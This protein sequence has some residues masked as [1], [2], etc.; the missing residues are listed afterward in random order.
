MLPTTSSLLLLWRYLM[1]DCSQNVLNTKCHLSHKFRNQRNPRSQLRQKVCLMRMHLSLH[2]MILS[3]CKETK[4]DHMTMLSLNVHLN[5]C[6]SNPDMLQGEH[7]MVMSHLVAL[8]ERGKVPE[9]MGMYTCLAPLQTP[10]DIENCLM[11]TAQHLFLTQDSQ[12][13]LLR[14]TLVMLNQQWKG[15]HCGNICFQRQYLTTM[16]YQI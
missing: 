16:N 3:F 9:K 4:R 2:P 12:A 11:Q 15:E 10:T 6:H 1:N 13:T 7:S 5:C 14:V 8:S